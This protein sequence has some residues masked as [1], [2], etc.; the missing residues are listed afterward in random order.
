MPEHQRIQPDKPAQGYDFNALEDR[1]YNLELRNEQSDSKHSSF[2]STL[3]FPILVGI[4]TYLMP[5]ILAFIASAV[6][7]VQLK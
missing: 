7:G 3:W 2:V 1:V 4:F 6:A 5:Y